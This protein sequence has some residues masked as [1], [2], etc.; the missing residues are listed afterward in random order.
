MTRLNFRVW[1]K[2]LK[3]IV[4]TEDN[5]TLQI[6]NNELTVAYS[7]TLHQITNYE[8]LES[9][10]LK[11]KNGTEI[12]EGDIL[13]VSRN[14][15]KTDERCFNDEKINY[16]VEFVVYDDMEAYADI[17]HY[18]WC[19]VSETNTSRCTLIDAVTLW[20]GT[21]V[22]NIYEHRGLLDNDS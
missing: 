19:A 22:S 20:R 17:E 15:T 5:L 3:T 10:G 2:D 1:D 13:Q 16:V 11:D 9:T 7:D 14:H 21:V 12:Y 6:T 18:G 8:L 4:S